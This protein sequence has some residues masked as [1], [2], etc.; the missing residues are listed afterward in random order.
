MAL[1]DKYE[2]NKKDYDNKK[3]PT[4]YSR[5]S[6]A[7]SESTIDPSKLGASFWNG[8]LKLSISPSKPGT[9]EYDH[10]NAGAVHLSHFKAKLFADEI[11]LFLQNPETYANQ[12]V[13]SGA[14]LVSITNGKELTGKLNPCLVIRKISEDGKIE[15]TYVYEFKNNYHYAIRNYDD[16]DNSFDK[17]YNNNLELQLLHTLLTEY[18]TSVNGAM[19]YSVID[20]GRFDNSRVNTKLDSIAEKLGVE[21]GGKSGGNKRSSSSVFDKK[22]GRNYSIED[23]DGDM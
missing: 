17:I 20:Y 12:G 16:K 21:Y 5:F 3:N 7:N 13:P 18:Y 6:L 15:S 22:E 1:G 9:Q 23:L 11:A 2:N 10:D 14:G 8:L 4:V 19:A